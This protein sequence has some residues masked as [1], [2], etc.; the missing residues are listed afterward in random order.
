[1]RDQVLRISAQAV[2][3]LGVVQLDGRPARTLQSQGGEP[4]KTVYLDPQ[5]GLP[6]QITVAWPSRQATFTYAS[7]EI[8]T[9]LNDQLFSLEVPAGYTLFRGEVFKPAPDHRAKML[10]KM[11]HLVML[12]FEY[13]DKHAD[14]FPADLSELEETGVT[15]S[16]QTLLAAPDQPAGPPIIQYRRP[17]EGA[18]RAS[19]IVV[20]EAPAYR[21]EGKIV[22][23]MADGHAEVLTQERFEELMR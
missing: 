7:I 13:A 14:R 6:L 20:F 3:D 2:K 19:E 4:V 17:R 16:L 15:G 8:D 10:A 23:G 5:T 21:H 11:K 1:M 22:V 18:N 12:C 9:E